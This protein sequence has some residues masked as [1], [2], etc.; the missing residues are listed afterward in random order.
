VLDAL[1]IVLTAVFFWALDRYAVA[2]E[3]L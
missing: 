3:K 2:L 1:L